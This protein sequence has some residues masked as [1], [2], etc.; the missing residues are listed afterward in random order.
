MIAFWLT[1]EDYKRIA[2]WED[3][4][5][6]VSWEKQVVTVDKND[7]SD[8]ILDDGNNIPW[9]NKWCPIDPALRVQCESCQ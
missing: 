8:D 6:I 9:A 3:V 1:L 5:Y 4:D 2:N 7:L